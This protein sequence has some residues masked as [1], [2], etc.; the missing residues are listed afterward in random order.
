[1]LGRT[2][3]SEE[4]GEHLEIRRELESFD[5]TLIARHCVACTR[6]CESFVE[7]ASSLH[8]PISCLGSSLLTTSR[9][10][11]R[12]SCAVATE[13]D[14]R[15]IVELIEPTPFQVAVWA[16]LSP[17]MDGG[18]DT[19]PHACGSPPSPRYADSALLAEIIERYPYLPQPA[20]QAVDHDP[21]VLTLAEPRQLR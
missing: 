8:R 9:R 6:R 21:C 18:P 19:T 10:T 13:P 14:A 17:S 15:A 11:T 20:R 2:V 16:L 7:N 4:I 3:P 12:D 5:P 1:M